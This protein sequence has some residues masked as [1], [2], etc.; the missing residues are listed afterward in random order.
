MQ[1][2]I[3]VFQSVKK[4]VFW[5][6]VK[7]RGHPPPAFDVEKSN[8]SGIFRNDLHFEYIA[9]FAFL[10]PV[11]WMVN[12]P[13]LIVP[14]YFKQLYVGNVTGEYSIRAEHS[15]DS[16]YNYKKRPLVICTIMQAVVCGSRMRRGI[17]T[18]GS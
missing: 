1:N 5:Q 17:E 8:F 15:F 7:G 14:E 12:S 16:I 9:D 18:Q 10:L 3:T 13:P 6:T 4:L 2:A 11:A